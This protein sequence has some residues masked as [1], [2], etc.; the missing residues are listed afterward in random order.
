MSAFKAWFPNILTLANAA[1]GF[2]SLISLI[3]GRFVQ[4]ALWMFFA[5]VFDGIDGKVASILGSKSQLGSHLD[6]L[7][8]VISFGLVPG[9]SV[10]LFFQLYPQPSLL[11]QIAAWVGGIGYTCASIL[12]ETRF[13]VSQA[14]RERGQGFIGLPIAPPA[15][16]NVA[17]LLLANL[18]PGTLYNPLGLTFVFF[19]VALNASLMTLSNINYLRWSGR[20]MALQ[21]AISVVLGIGAY[22]A[23][24]TL[25]AFLTFFFIGFCSV[26]ILT[27][28]VLAALHSFSSRLRKPTDPQLLDK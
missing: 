16:L 9:V 3:E 5:T 7:S 4:G 19:I 24:G 18:F 28:L 8:D 20:A 17:L 26:Y 2:V 23:L 6:S 1:C 12:R 11:T 22:L 14:D 10:Y 25:G 21:A 15:G 13:L 27:H